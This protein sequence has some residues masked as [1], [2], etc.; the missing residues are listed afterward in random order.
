MRMKILQQDN[1]GSHYRA[2]IYQLMDKE[3]DCDFCFGD[4]C[5]KKSGDNI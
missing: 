4:E 1:I 5:Y 3:L 2:A